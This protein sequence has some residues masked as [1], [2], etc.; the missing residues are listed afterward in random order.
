MLKRSTPNYCAG[1]IIFVQLILQRNPLQLIPQPRKANG[2]IGRINI[3][4]KGER[5][6]NRRIS[7]PFYRVL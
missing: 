5:G 1:S 2:L 7:V 6:I 4:Q 3:L